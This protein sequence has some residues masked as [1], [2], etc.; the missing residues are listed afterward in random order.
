MKTHR[1]IRDVFPTDW[2][3]NRTILVRFN[4]EA[5]KSVGVFVEDII[6]EN[7]DGILAIQAIVKL[8]FDLVVLV[9][10]WRKSR[11][12]RMDDS[13]GARGNQL[14]KLALVRNPWSRIPIIII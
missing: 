10:Q 7:P 12:L 4:G 3:P 11:R 13:E 8:S 2:S 6:F 1:V 9:I 14:Q 5:V